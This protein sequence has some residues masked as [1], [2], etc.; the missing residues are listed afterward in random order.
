[1]YE[2]RRIQSSAFGNYRIPEL[3]LITYGFGPLGKPSYGYATDMTYDLRVTVLP[4]TLNTLFSE[5]IRIED[6]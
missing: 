4:K 6:I 5:I 1:M 3:R 2:W